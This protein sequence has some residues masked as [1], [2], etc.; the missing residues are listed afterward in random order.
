M[1]FAATFLAVGRS[2]QSAKADC[3]IYEH[4]AE[5]VY[6]TLRRKLSKAIIVELGCQDHPLLGSA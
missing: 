2:K 3:R 1:P 6:L 4:I 5:T